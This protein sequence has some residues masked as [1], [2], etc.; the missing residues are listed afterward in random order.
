MSARLP[1]GQVQPGRRQ[2]P[3]KESLESRVKSQPNALFFDKLKMTSLTH[4][5]LKVLLPEQQLLNIY[6]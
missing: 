2:R 3:K 1:D 4:H 5:F 6:P